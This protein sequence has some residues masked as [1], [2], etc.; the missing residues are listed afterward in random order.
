MSSSAWPLALFGLLELAIGHVY[1]RDLEITNWQTGVK[2]DG[3]HVV[4]KPLQLVLNGAPI[5]GNVDLNLAVPGYQYDVA[6]NADRVPLAPLA[7]TFSPKFRD[8]AKGQLLA[9]IQIKGAGITG[10]SLQKALNGKMGFTL[11]NADIQLPKDFKYRKVLEKLKAYKV[12]YSRPPMA[13]TDAEGKPTNEVA[14]YDPDGT[15]LIVV[16]EN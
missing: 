12:A 2:L 11:T 13:L 16:E 10:A 8:S 1:L 5:S 15:V 14:V 6:L 7:N 3:G 9:N 4:M